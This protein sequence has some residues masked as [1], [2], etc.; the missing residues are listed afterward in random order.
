MTASQKQAVRKA[1]SY[2][3]FTAFSRQGLIGQLQYEGFSREEATFAVDHI[4]VDWMEQ[5]AKKAQ[6]YLDMSSFSRASL[7]KQLKYEGFTNEQAKHGADAVGL[8]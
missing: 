7:I 4:D 1:E 3:S 8:K 5:A 6:S 2:L